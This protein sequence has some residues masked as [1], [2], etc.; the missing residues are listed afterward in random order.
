MWKNYKRKKAVDGNSYKIMRLLM[1]DQD[2][3]IKRILQ[4][5]IPVVATGLEPVTSRM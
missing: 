1:P 4:W 5:R 3:E 2:F